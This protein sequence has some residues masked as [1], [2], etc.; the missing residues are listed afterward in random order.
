MNHN[1]DYITI[2]SNGKICLKDKHALVI[3]VNGHVVLEFKPDYIISKRYMVIYKNIK[4]IGESDNGI[5][6]DSDSAA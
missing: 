6:A 3:I 1:E 5:P 4:Y 2:H